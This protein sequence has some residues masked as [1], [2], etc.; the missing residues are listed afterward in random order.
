M[1][2]VLRATR[3]FTLVLVVTAVGS[4][5]WAQETERSPGGLF[6]RIFGGSERFGGGE[7]VAQPG[8]QAGL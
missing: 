2:F 3:I 5:A 4:P 8:G 1:A 7:R 6:D